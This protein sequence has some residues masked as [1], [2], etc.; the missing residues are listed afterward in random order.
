MQSA[1]SLQILFG[2]RIRIRPEYGARA[3]QQKWC[4][5]KSQSPISM[6]AIIGEAAS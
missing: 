3:R 2:G 6:A 5:G 1:W 4:K